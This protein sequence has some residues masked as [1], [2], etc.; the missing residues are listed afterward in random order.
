VGGISV[1]DI[2]GG[3]FEVESRRLGF[4]NVLLELN[5]MDFG[6]EAGMI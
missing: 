4:S 2:D 3:F 6:M 5:C 1:S